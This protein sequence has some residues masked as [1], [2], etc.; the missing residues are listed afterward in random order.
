MNRQLSPSPVLLLLT[1]LLLGQTVWAAVRGG[2][3]EV[4]LW[5]MNGL[6]LGI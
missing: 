6:T 3:T 4:D 1:A 2:Q 5:V